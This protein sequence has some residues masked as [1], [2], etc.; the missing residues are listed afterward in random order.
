MK[1]HHH[2][3]WDCEQCCRTVSLESLTLLLSTWA[4][5]SM[6]SLALSAHMSLW[7]IHF[8]VLKAHSWTLEGL[9]LPAMKGDSGELFFAVTDIL[10]IWSTE[11]PTHFLTNGPDPVAAARTLLSLV[12]SRH[13]QLARVPWPGKEQEIL[14][15]SFPFPLSFLSLTLPILPFFKSPSPGRRSLV[16][17]PQSEL[18]VGRERTRILVLFW[19]LVGPSSSPPFPGSSG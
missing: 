19:S 17:G 14:L 8:W 13:G 9:P 4:P 12:F 10:T 1:P 2:K 16:K 18:R 11:G 7:T 6:R 5:L 15:T 3:T